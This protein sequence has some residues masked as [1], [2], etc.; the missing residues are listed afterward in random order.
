MGL[1]LEMLIS[2]F[3][4]RYI[5]NVYVAGMLAAEAG[6]DRV[7]TVFSLPYGFRG[8]LVLFADILL[9]TIWSRHSEFRAVDCVKSSLCREFLN[10]HPSL[11]EHCFVDEVVD[12]P[13]QW[14][15]GVIAS[16]IYWNCQPDGDMGFHESTK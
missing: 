13:R 10:V 2:F 11:A 12:A 8:L 1:L 16:C 3:D 14:R 9:A 6:V 15:D 5:Y 4:I 7:S